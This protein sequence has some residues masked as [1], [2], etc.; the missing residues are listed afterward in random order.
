MEKFKSYKDLNVYQKAFE[1]AM[2]IFELS[3][4]FP[5]EE[6]Y[7]LTDQIRRS[8]RS[9]CANVAEGFRRR[10]YIQSFCNCISISEGEASETQ[11]WLDFA[12]RCGYI[13]EEVY[14]ELMNE[15]EHI[16]GML[17][18]MQKYSDKWKI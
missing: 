11:N 18:N 6:T 16:I 7:S 2:R 10:K 3:K 13:S 17:V 4:F 1:A 9:V 14:E 8:S 5:K 12:F 15:Y